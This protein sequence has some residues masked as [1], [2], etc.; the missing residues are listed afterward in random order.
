MDGVTIPDELDGFADDLAAA[1]SERVSEQ[2][3]DELREEL[4]SELPPEI[5]QKLSGDLESMAPEEGVS[6]YL[7]EKGEEV[8]PG[9]LEQYRV[10]MAYVERYLT[11]VCELTSLDDLTPRQAAD[12]KRWRRE[13]SLDREEPLARKT[14]KDDMHLFQGF[15]KHMARLRAVQA[16]AYEAVEIPK[17]TYGDGVDKQTLDPKRAAAILEFLGRYRPGRLD[18]IVLLLLI[19]T[20]RRPSGLRA[21]DLADFDDSGEEVTLSFVHRPDTG[22]PLKGNENHEALLTLSTEAGHAIRE[23][24]ETWRPDVRDGYDRK[25]LLAT[26]NGRISKSTIREYSYKWTRPITIKSEGPDGHDVETCPGAESAKKASKCSASR[27]PRM[28]RSG[29]ITAML[30]GGASYEAVGYRVGATKPALKKHYDHPNDEEERKRHFKE[31]VDAGSEDDRGYSQMDESAE[32][33][34]DGGRSS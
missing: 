5:V 4:L 15:L 28:I 2:V 20:G 8:S 12:F 7:E 14:L 29:Y 21:L 17:L 6:R 26:A 22:T 33:V 18:Y 13:E 11:D 30:N 16:E 25:P 3:A 10:K 32:L 27:S 23:Y 1:V 34:A 31:I 24:I 9:T 19:K